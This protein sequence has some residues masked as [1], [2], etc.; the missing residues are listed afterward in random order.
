MRYHAA[1]VESGAPGA[2]YDV[3]LPDFPRCTSAGDTAEQAIANAAEALFFHMEGM[4]EDGLPVLDPDPLDAP[5][6][7]WLDGVDGVRVLVEPPGKAVRV[8]VT[9]DAALLARIDRAADARHI[10]RSG[11]LAEAAREKLRG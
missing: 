3:V 10:S 5:L 11:F 7:D 1:L 6:P 9:I 4:A 8:N 2:G